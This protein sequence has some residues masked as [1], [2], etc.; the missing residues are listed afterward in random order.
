MEKI[1][2]DVKLLVIAYLKNGA[3]QRQVSQ[4]LE[5]AKIN[6]QNIW[7]KYSKVIRIENRVSLG[8]TRKW[9]KRDERKLVITSKR[10][11]FLTAK[12]LGE[13]M[14]MHKY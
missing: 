3:S 13:C 2:H 6:V 1:S 14:R 5:I 8:R 7:D 10:N 4:K 11:P 12:E 9:S